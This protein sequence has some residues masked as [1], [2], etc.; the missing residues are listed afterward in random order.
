MTHKMDDTLELKAALYALGTLT[1]NEARN[2]AESLE[3]VAEASR[4]ELQ[5]FENVVELLGLSADDEMPSATVGERIAAFAAAHPRLVPP[6]ETAALPEIAA[7][8]FITIRRDEGEWLQ[9][10]EGVFLKPV[11]ENKK[12]GTS[13]YLLKMNPNTRTTLHRHPG[14][15]E[16][17]V[18]EGD[19]HVDG[20]DLSAGDYHCAL[21][22][23]IHERP[24]TTGGALVLIVANGYELLE[25]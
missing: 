9:P 18:I 22:G 14:I 19:F 24:G 16:C 2:F 23:S 6:Q 7:H 5:E 25:Q 8:P 13:T 4:A 11:F 3:D 15:E 21:E 12:N 17:V 20:K 1:Q 10:Y